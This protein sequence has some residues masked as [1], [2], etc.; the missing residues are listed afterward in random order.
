MY[1]AVTRVQMSRDRSNYQH[2]QNAVVFGCSLILLSIFFAFEYAGEKKV[3]E[4][5]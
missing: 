2:L 4:C 3:L 1:F 5:L